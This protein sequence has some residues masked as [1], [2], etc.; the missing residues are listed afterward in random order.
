MSYCEKCEVLPEK[1]I[2]QGILYL[3]PAI[4]P[5][6]STL[7]RGMEKLG[8][9]YS[10]QKG[11]LSVG[12]SK[13]ELAL[14]LR[15]G[16]N[17]QELEDSRALYVPED[18]NPEFRDLIHMNS[19]LSLKTRLE[20]DWLIELL[21]NKQLT[22]YF[23]PIL[24][25]DR[26]ERIFAR[27]ALLRT[28]EGAGGKTPDVIF[29][30]AR[31]AGLLFYLDREARV[32]AVKTASSRGFT[33]TLFINFNPTSIYS[34]EHCLQ[35]TKQ[36]V[37]EAGFTPDQIVFE[38]VE[39]DYIRDIEKML[40]IVKYYRSNGFRVAL[41]DL[42]AGYGSLNLLSKL[43]PDF[44]KLDMDLVKGVHEDK[45]KGIITRNLLKIARELGV[46]TIA[47]GVE[48][49]DEL[50][51]VQDAGADFVQGFLFGRPQP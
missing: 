28:K 19:L 17:H 26:P 48:T 18:H 8:L 16:L 39:S 20:G 42:G 35:T 24:Y 13:A 7:C 10:R 47:E 45:Y 12:I 36:A 4:A 49:E 14:L 50:S 3:S 21:E 43:Q 32:T 11:L 40:S 2:D 25:A 15:E 29:S 37:Q 6:E 30:T 27:E 51:W 41:D 31:D 46:K 22:S 9:N 34:P 1:L 33:D 38:I 23:Q 44:V 5:T